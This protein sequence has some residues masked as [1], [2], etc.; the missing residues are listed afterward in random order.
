MRK[1]K[2][3]LT[4]QKNEFQSMTKVKKC[5]IKPNWDIFKAKFSENPQDNFEWFC[6]LLFCKEF[7]K[8]LGVSGYKNH[9]HLEHN[10]IEKDR[11]IIGWQGKFY[12]T[13]LPQHKTEII[14]LVEGAKKDYPNLTKI[15]LYTNKNWSQGK[16][17]NDPQAKLNIDNKSKELDIEIDWN[18]MENFFKSPFVSVDNELISKKFFT[19]DKSIFDLIDEQQKHTE[20]ILNEIQTHID[21]NGKAIKIKRN[22]ILEKLKDGSSQVLVLSGVAGVGKTALVKNIYEDTKGKAPFYIFKAT[23]FELRNISDFF[24]NFDFQDFIKAYKE[25]T[26]KT[27]VIDSA[28]KLLDLKNPD[29]FKEFLTILVENNW[30]IIF[31]TRDNYLEDLNY[32]FFEI[33]NIVPLNINLQNLEQDDLNSISS[34][35]S[36]KLPQDQK[37]LELIKNPF[38]LNEYLKFYKDD[39]EMDYAGFKEKLWNKNIK[40]N[41]PARSECFLK[42]AIKRA[43]QGGFFVIPNCESSILNGLVGDGILGYEENNGYFI[44]HDIYEEWALEKK[45]N[46]EYSQKTNNQKFFENIGQSLPIRRSFRNWV[47]EKLLLQDQEIGNFIEAII[48]DGQIQSFWKD[49][50]L[51]FILLSAYS[52]VFFKNF[53]DSLLENE[54]EL[55]KKITFLLRIACKEVDE[56]F[57]KQLGI[58]RIDLFTLK[59]VLTKPKGQGWESVIKFVY[60]NLNTIGIGNIYFILPIIHDWN[61]KFKEGDTTKLSSLIALRLYQ[62]SNEE[63]IHILL[64]EDTEDKI[65]QTILFGAS[66]IRHELE[67]IFEEINANKWKYHQDPY[68]GLSEIILTKLEGINIAKVLPEYVLKLAELFWFYAPKQNSFYP[69]SS[70]GMEQYF[71]L[72]EHL[73]YY[74]PSAYQTP[75]YWLLQSSLQKTVDFILFFTNKAMACFAK[76]DLGRNEVKEIK[77]FFKE[78]NYIIQLIGDRIWN[79][80]RGTQVSPPVLQSMHMALEK[81]FLERGKD[82]DS[83]TLES[84]LLYLLK[85]SKSASISA[86]VTS[87]V[88]TFPE[89]TFNIAKILFQTKEFFHFD[90]KRLVYEQDA[91]SLYSIGYGLNYQN[92]IYQDERIKTCDDK[93]RKKSLEDLALNYQFFRDE[94]ISEEEVKKRQKVIWDIF[95]NYYKELTDKSKEADIDWRICLARMD[96]RKMKPTAEIKNNQILVSFNPEIDPILIKHSEESLKIIS[97]SMRYSS[98]KLWA[99][100]KM[101]NDKNYEQYEEY[102]KNPELTL[103]EVKEIIVKLESIIK[104]KPLPIKHSNDESFYLFNYT[105]PAEV[106]SVLVRDYL[107][108]L[109]KEEKGFCK[110]IVLTVASSSFRKG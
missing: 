49:E 59:Y 103:K 1:V 50:V 96:R 8:P 42:I 75:I 41:K 16:K 97:E 61:S 60:E 105:I 43:R 3:M 4:W 65:L 72:E 86:V 66:E 5:I 11:E 36:F 58:K 104:P 35:Y 69:H 46:R 84:W 53:K 100:Y 81:F 76:S 55:L 83:K 30:K 40:K 34:T 47:S 87:I 45:I 62:F 9:R 108:I 91:K 31:T 44:T 39:G 101:E 51:I 93:H 73:H 94:K 70:I 17:Q 25:E 54:Q 90:I 99:K 23:E 57:F 106:C 22:D 38:I 95:D 109:S 6:Y 89:K 52:D 107:E 13:P 33:Y 79:I 19:L 56:D 77:V 48:A 7:N 15:I 68:Y 74:P 14:G 27:I 98:L 85:N 110:D 20:N 26:S 18:H 71:C 67:K 21:F 92:N 2:N 37:L 80:Y 82:A 28:E 12:D 24:K 32:Q 10:P 78:D 29:P 102:E 88:L 64:D 63:D